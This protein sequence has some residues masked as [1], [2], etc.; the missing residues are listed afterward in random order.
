[1]SMLSYYV[2]DSSKSIWFAR[3]LLVLQKNICQS[4]IIPHFP[5][6]SRSLANLP[7]CTRAVLQGAVQHFTTV[8]R[9]VLNFMYAFNL[10]SCRLCS[11]CTMHTRRISWMRTSLGIA[12][13][14]LRII[15]AC[16]LFKL[17]TCYSAAPWKSLSYLLRGSSRSFQRS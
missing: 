2:R 9:K 6:I 12:P 8:S 17:C 15:W 11:C 16:N 5:P 1:M 13:K 7:P 10:L 4:S 14:L 3:E